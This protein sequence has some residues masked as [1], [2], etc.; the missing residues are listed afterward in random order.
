MSR[1]SLNTARE[2]L[3]INAVQRMFA[4]LRMRR[5]EIFALVMLAVLYAVFEGF[6]I[7]LLLPVLQYVEFGASAVQQ[8]GGQGVWGIL[9]STGT[10]LGITVNLATLLILS[11]IPIVLRQLTFF[12]NTWYATIVQNRAVVR[13]RTSGFE[14]LVHTDLSF[15]KS[16]SQGDL[17]AFL[18]GQV[19]TA[20]GTLLQF[21]R[22]IAI[23]VL[24][25]AYLGVLFFL[26]PQLTLVSMTAVVAMSIAVRANIKRSRQYGIHLTA[27]ARE[28]YI[29]FAEKV[30]FL[31][32]VKM[33]GQEEAE[34]EDVRRLS[35]SLAKASKQIALSTAGIEV[36][37]DPGLMLGAFIVLFIG[38]QYLHLTL[39]GLGVFLFVLLR[40]NAKAKEFN[41]GRQ[42]F[43][44]SLESLLFVERTRKEAESARW[45]LGGDSTFGG[46][47]DSIVFEDV[48]YSYESESGREAVLVSV[49]AVIPANSM[50]AIVGKSGAGKSTL[51]GLIP[52]LRDCTSGRILLDGKDIRDFDLRSLRRRMGY[53]T[54][55]AML[56]NMSVYDNLVYGLET[57]P[58]EHEIRE[59]LEQSYAAPFLDPLPEGLDT[60]IGDRGARFSGG[61]RQRLALARVLLEDPDILILDE[62]TSSLDSESEE[63]ISK[64]LDTLRGRK[65]IIVIAHR[66]ATIQESDQ[67]L[68]LESGGIVASGTHAEL[69]EHGGSYRRLFDSQLVH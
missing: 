63:Y 60:L 2:V 20:S 19:E 47:S 14:S 8:S 32:L 46:L 36:I 12:A 18:T 27:L 1:V 6:G 53:M 50:T 54:Q 28:A 48:G 22:L 23:L 61:E 68:L 62:P 43:S 56:F 41:I 42:G 26:S 7:S 37:I 64:A 10:R 38:V 35:V 45:I 9:I 69:L 59:A 39:A 65:T 17:I 33:R 11:F 51:V 16:K 40:L 21:V 4:M 30:G 58:T 31:T 55:E 34:V 24:L 44:A 52:R 29:A 13:L 66:L 67:I 57:V 5:M 49:D 3:K 15:I 25:I